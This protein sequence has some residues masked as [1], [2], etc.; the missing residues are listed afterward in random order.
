MDLTY[1]IYKFILYANT[2]IYSITNDEK[3]GCGFEGERYMGL[4]RGG[5]GEGEMS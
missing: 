5:K 4:F 1:Y 3:R 2:Y